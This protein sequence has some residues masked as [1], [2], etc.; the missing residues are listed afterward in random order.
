MSKIRHS[1]TIPSPSVRGQTN[2]VSSIHSNPRCTAPPKRTAFFGSDSASRVRA[3]FC[4]RS[5]VARRR[6]RARRFMRSGT[7]AVKCGWGLTPTTLNIGGMRVRTLLAALLLLAACGE[8]DPVVRTI[9]RVA[10]AAEDRDAAEVI[11]AL[12]STYPGRAEAAQELRRY[13]FGY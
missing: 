5:G 6:S 2:V 3:F 1:T 13:F 9:D 7:L 11:E 12:A 8:K 4:A 10:N